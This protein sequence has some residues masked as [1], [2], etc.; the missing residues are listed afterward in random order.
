MN[1]VREI[2]KFLAVF[3]VAAASHFFAADN[4]AF[5]ASATEDFLVMIFK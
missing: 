2:C 4:L 5:A 1:L 3:S